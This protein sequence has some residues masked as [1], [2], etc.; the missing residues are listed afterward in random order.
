MT[1]SVA[2]VCING[3]GMGHATRILA[4]ARRLPENIT[5]VI[6]SN[7]PAL[8]AFEILPRAIVEH[9]P[10]LEYVDVSRNTWT[11]QLKRE[12]EAVLKLYGCEVVVQDGTALFPWALDSVT[13]GSEGRRLVWIRRPM[14]RD[15]RQVYR[16][17]AD[18]AWCDLV[19]EPGELAGDLDQGPTTRAGELA[20][21]PMRFVRTAPIRLL[22]PEETLPAGEARHRLGIAEGEK[23]V[24]VQLGAGTLQRNW[25]AAAAAIES[26]RKLGTH[27]IFLARWKIAGAQPRFGPDVTV[28]DTY[29]LARFFSAFDFQIAAAGY[30]SFHELLAAGQRTVIVPNYMEVDDQAL[31]ASYA[32]TGGWG[33]VVRANPL[34]TLGARMDEAIVRIASARP[35]FPPHFAENGALTAAREIA[36]LCGA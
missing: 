2:F 12:F 9:V 19:I 16:N 1:R 34:E 7:S 18:Q 31:R 23:A 33:A 15:R 26:L 21:P 13:R 10:G 30:N 17:L 22:D 24:L 29:P 28:I 36:A 32:E 6:F 3:T 11:A 8:D 5:P 25:D 27:R 35:Q 14:W 4:I 20:P